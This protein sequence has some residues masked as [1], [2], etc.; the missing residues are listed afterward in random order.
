MGTAVD[1]RRTIL[2]IEDEALVR[3]V[4]ADALQELGFA[5][6][7]AASAAE[8]LERFRAQSGS[9]A[10]AIIDVGLP[11]RSGDLLAA[12]LRALAPELPLVIASGYGQVAL[13]GLAGDPHVH[14]LAKPY[15]SAQL[16]GLLRE[17]GLS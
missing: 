7:E 13:D 2:V 8:G 3:M 1:H 14:F 12:D 4:T 11:D 16:E 6:E 15:S 5:V 9:I 17:L 10:V